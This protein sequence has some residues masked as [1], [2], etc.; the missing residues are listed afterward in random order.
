[1]ATL[2]KIRNRGG[3]LMLVVGLA[4]FAFIMTDLFQS[5]GASG[6]STQNVVGKVGGKPIS[7]EEYNRSLSL[8]LENAQRNRA[9]S[10]PEREQIASRVWEGM[11]RERLIS[12]EIEKVGIGVTTDE[13]AY[14]ISTKSDPFIEQFFGA[15]P[16]EQIASYINNVEEMGE[17]SAF[18]QW[19]TFK[20]ELRTKR[21]YEKYFTLLSKGMETTERFVQANTNPNKLN[22]QYV[23]RPYSSIPD[24]TI[25]I[26]EKEIKEY[27]KDHKEEFKGF[28]SRKIE[29]LNI[30]VSPSEEDFKNAE[31]YVKGYI[32]DFEAAADPMQYARNSDRAPST[33]FL[34]K[35]QIDEP[36][37][38]TFA[39]SGSDEV[40]G[41]YE[42][43]ESFKMVRVNER[44]MLP[45]SVRASHILIAPET[46]T[47]E[48]VVQMQALADSLQKLLDEGADFATLAKEY[49][50]DA[51]T[52]I[53]GG[54]LGWFPAGRM[55]LSFE[56]AAFNAKEGEV[57]TTYTQSGLHLIKVTK[58]GVLNEKVQLA[59]YTHEVTASSK[60]FDSFQREARH[61]VEEVKDVEG[62][63]SIAKEKNIPLTPLTLFPS[64]AGIQNIPNSKAVVR[65]AFEAENT[66]KLLRTVENSSVFELDNSYMVAAVTQISKK[67]YKSL[68]EVRAQIEAALRNQKK[69]EII[70][71]EL[72]KLTNSSLE[73]IATKE[74]VTV[75]E[76]ENVSFQS[77]FLTGLGQE[78][79]VVAVATSGALKA[80]EVSQPIEG[81]DGVFLISVG[82]KT[83]T[84][85]DPTEALKQYN[86]S[87]SQR[88][89]G[90]Y[91]A[92]YEK[93]DVEDKR[94]K[95]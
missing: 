14:I 86:L 20:K 85:T 74:G 2:Q 35:E 9:L 36:E 63:R 68:E 91:Q 57:V 66:N 39:F 19:E 42:D 15:M 48:A 60:T 47:E 17:G 61:I 58:R 40:Y 89:Q 46:P 30:E 27:Y 13:I 38:A 75:N 25:K 88:L 32:K 84:T 3:L 64:S 43:G 1:M 87:L 90:A 29:Y 41:P 28:D 81:R 23:K 10:V 52:A 78:P 73:E 4:L 69:A 72:A 44:K 65:A 18:E 59:T 16:A 34:R 92:L 77:T 80:G 37:L 93:A 94:Y 49:S 82:E 76:I 70:K 54:D 62:L 83:Q 26:A 12:E 67:G 7:Y 56:E 55:F 79:K 95:F 71:A 22:V 53:N 31:E 6:G 45:D 8:A 21:T 5:G 33:M 11:V 51:E 50:A 24:S